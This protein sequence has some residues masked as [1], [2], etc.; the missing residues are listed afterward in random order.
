MAR[1]EEAVGVDMILVAT[2]R[3]T[4]LGYDTT[5]PVTMEDM[6][7]SLPPSGVGP[8]H[9]RSRRYALHVL[10]DERGRSHLQRWRFIKEAGADAVKLEGAPK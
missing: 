8:Q 1:F 2:R 6:L 7:P 9:I 10:S 3:H 5:L 4:D